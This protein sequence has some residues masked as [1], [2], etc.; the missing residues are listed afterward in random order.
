MLST[1]CLN[2]PP[3][4]THPELFDQLQAAHD[5]PEQINPH[6]C[7]EIP[8]QSCWDGLL[9]SICVWDF[10]VCVCVK[11]K[12][13]GTM[14]KSQNLVKNERFVTH[15]PLTEKKKITMHLLSQKRELFLFLS[16]NNTPENEI[17]SVCF[18]L[19]EIL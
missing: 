11:F 1:S 9:L 18:I 7:H 16:V 4:P 15:K 13:T 12:Q 3:T 5:L 2:P 14:G 19:P 17:G 6:L 8:V 10:C